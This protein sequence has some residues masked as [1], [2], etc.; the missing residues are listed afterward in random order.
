[1]TETAAPAPEAAKVPALNIP[2]AALDDA[3]AREKAKTPA[4]TPEAKPSESEKRA[5]PEAKPE[6]DADKQ[7]PKVDR[8][9]KL[10]ARHQQLKAESASKDQEIARLKARNAELEK[11]P[12]DQLTAEQQQAAQ[13]R[14]TLNSD[15]IETAEAD[16]KAIER[17]AA[18]ARYETLEEKANDARSRIPDFDAAWDTMLANP[19]SEVGFEFLAESE[20]GAEIAYHLGKNPAEA[21]RIYQLDPVRQAVEFARIEGRLSAPAVRKVSQAP[22]PPPTLGGSNAPRSKSYAEMSMDEYAAAYKARNKG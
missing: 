4:P 13:L 11:L 21:R 17:Q 5:D 8:Y 14:H 22:T 3:E 9:G 12:W 1:M 15:R 2:Q 18:L 10:H 6:D 7:K 19:L 20:K 16:A